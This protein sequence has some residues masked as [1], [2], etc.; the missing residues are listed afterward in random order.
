MEELKDEFDDII[1]DII[2][3][4]V[5]DTPDYSISKKELNYWV[6]WLFTNYD[7]KEKVKN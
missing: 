5:T 1:R 4:V 3:D 2:R 6:N 7:I